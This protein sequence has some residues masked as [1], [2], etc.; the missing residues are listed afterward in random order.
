[1]MK[2]GTTV[3]TSDDVHAAPL[4][5][6]RLGQMFA[7]CGCDAAPL[8]ERASCLAPDTDLIRMTPTVAAARCMRSSIAAS[9]EIEMFE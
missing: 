3:E 9:P 4:V 5:E 8:F 2:P 6:R 1:M 7:E